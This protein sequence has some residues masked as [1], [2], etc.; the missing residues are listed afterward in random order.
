MAVGWPRF[1]KAV[2]LGALFLTACLTGKYLQISSSLL[3]IPNESS[4]HNKTLGFNRIVVVSTG[5]TW[6]IEGLI[7]AAKFTNLDVDVPRQ[8][9]WNTKEVDNFRGLSRADGARRIGPG[10]T[11]CWLGHLHALKYI[12]ENSLASALIMEDDVDWDINIKQQLILVAPAI[13]SITNSTVHSPE[14]PFGNA[15]DL[16]WVGHCGDAIPSNTIALHDATLPTT[17]GYRENDGRYIILAT[18]PQMR[19]VH[20]TKTPLCTYAYAVT[21]SAAK[22]IHTYSQN[23]VEDIITT[24][25]KRWCQAGFLRCVTVNPELFH[26]HKKAGK[27]TSEIAVL[28]GWDDLS[29]PWEVDFTANIRYS[30]RCNSVSKTAGLVTCS[31]EFGKIKMRDGNVD[32]NEDGSI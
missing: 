26:H 10:Q 22:K 13:L 8:P 3:E 31:D 32:G 4:I 12:I 15:W 5:S 20:E 25:L 18:A 29:A 14:Q 2:V 21:L 11:K 19:F 16:L 24:D 23:G 1:A 17:A 7:E 30:A 27:V 9:N 28:E 6:R